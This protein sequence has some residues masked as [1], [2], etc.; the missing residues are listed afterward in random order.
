MKE[1]EVK[2]RVTNKKALFDKLG[3]LGI[4]LSEPI[5][6]KDRVFF[7]KGVEFAK[8]NREKALRIRDQDGT[9]IF[10]YKQPQKNNLDKIEYES[11]ISDP[12]DLASICLELG[13]EET[14]RI[15]KIR[16]KGVYGDYEVCFDEV[17]NLGAFIEVEKLSLDGDSEA[18]QAD[19]FAFLQTLG[20]TEADRMHEGYDIL[21]Y[22]KLNNIIEQE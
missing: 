9:F 3:A 14:V 20:I 18:I 8:R 1:I 2:A 12:E 19:L 16:Q 11:K 7:P 5:S 15:Q 6:Q 22:K 21:L 13:F 17:E 4:V 10:T